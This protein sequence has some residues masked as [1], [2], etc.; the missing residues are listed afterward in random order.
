M[1]AI[2]VVVEVG[3]EG[4]SVC[5]EGVESGEGFRF[6]LLPPD[7]KEWL[8]FDEDP[9][10]PVSLERPWV[11]TWTDALAQLDPYPWAF[12]YP[13]QVHPAFGALVASALKD[14]AAHGEIDWA[15]WMPLLSSG[16][17]LASPY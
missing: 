13:L 11:D 2:F 7:G 17:A 1:E 15:A 9:P 4:G 6:R 12:L 10:E 16:D 3:A 5:L 14:R 8:M